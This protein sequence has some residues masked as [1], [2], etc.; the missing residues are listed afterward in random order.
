[1]NGFDTAGEF[2]A[3]SGCLQ[4]AQAANTL[5]MKKDEIKQKAPRQ[6]KQGQFVFSAIFFNVTGYLIK[7]FDLTL[8]HSR[9]QCLLDKSRRTPALNF[10]N[11]IILDEN[12]VLKWYFPAF[13]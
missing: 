9:D 13:V 8:R 6:R 2:I 1:M 5:Y 7:P 4:V 3:S 12:H 10:G 11:E